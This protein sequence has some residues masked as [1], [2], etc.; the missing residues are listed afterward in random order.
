MG[1]KF[2]DPKGVII[3]RISNDRQHNKEKAKKET[4]EQ[5]MIYK[6]QHRKLK[7]EQHEATSDELS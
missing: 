4:K 1:K 2:E 3:S 7:I 5:T 6:T